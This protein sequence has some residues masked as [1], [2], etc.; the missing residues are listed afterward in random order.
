MAGRED[1]CPPPSKIL[2]NTLIWN[3]VS[4]LSSY[5]YSR[6]PTGGT[7]TEMLSPI[8]ELPP[9]YPVYASLVQCQSAC[10]DRVHCKRRHTRNEF[11]EPHHPFV[12]HN[13]FV[14]CRRLLRISIH[15]VCILP[16]E[17]GISTKS[18]LFRETLNLIPA[19]WLRRCA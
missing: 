1:L 14:H 11:P 12:F 3:L 13:S 17:A 6:P 7:L 8:P 18:R 4:F 19:P 2:I 9:Q 5:I 10:G 16:S 15:G